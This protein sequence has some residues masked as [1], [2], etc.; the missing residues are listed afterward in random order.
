MA[1]DLY[2]LFFLLFPAVINKLIM[3]KEFSG[4]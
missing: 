1:D 2:P 3:A 4:T